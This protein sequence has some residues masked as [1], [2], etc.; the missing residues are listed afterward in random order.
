MEQYPDTDG[1]DRAAHAHA[2]STWGPDDFRACDYHRGNWAV[3]AR[4]AER[5][6][7][8]G[9]DSAD[10]ADRAEH[11]PEF[12]E[13]DRKYAVSLFYDPMTW[14]DGDEALVNGQHRLCALRA[15]GVVSCPVD[16]RHLPETVHEVTTA[17]PSAQARP[18][19]A[20][21]WPR[22][23]RGLGRSP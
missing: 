13:H 11:N 14:S 1:A 22:Y 2:L 8:A 16:G 10:M 5:A 9:G 15:A 12:D 21:F 19:A 3:I 4:A 7:A 20:G 17:T 23:V 18:H 6:L